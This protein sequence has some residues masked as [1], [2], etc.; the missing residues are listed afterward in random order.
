MEID[1][2]GQVG[3][4]GGDEGVHQ[5]RRQGE[6]LAAEGGHHRVTCKES[7]T[8]EQ[9]NTLQHELMTKTSTCKTLVHYSRTLFMMM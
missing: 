7:A 3:R 9:R 1:E 2:L 4:W 8:Q 5:V 6:S